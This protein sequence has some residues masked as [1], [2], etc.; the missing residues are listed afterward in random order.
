MAVLF[1]G[2]D[3]SPGG[4]KYNE[5]RCGTLQVTASSGRQLSVAVVCD[6]VGGEERGERA[7]QL[8]V[9]TFLHY[10]RQHPDEVFPQLLINGVQAA[11]YAV[12][13][14]A[15]LLG[16]A[17]RMACTLVAAVVENGSKAYIANVGDSRAYLCRAGQLR[18]LT[19]DHTFA[20]V[21]VWLGKL[22]TEAAAT[23]P[24]ANRVMRV[25]GTREDLQVDMGF[26]M[27]TTEYG[28]A[29]QIGRNGLALKRG[30][31]ILLCSDGLIKPTPRSRQKL[32]TEAEIARTL[33][34]LEGDK[35]AQALLGVAL[36][37]IPVGEQVD[38][39][40]VAVVQTPDPSR[41]RR[42]AL[43]SRR[44]QVLIALAVGLPLLFLLV[45]V[46][47]LFAGFFVFSSASAAGTATQL[48]Q[49]TLQ[50]ADRTRIAAGFTATPTL[51][52]T[53]LPTS[54]PTAV[55][56]EVAKVF[57]P[58]NLLQ[59]II[60]TDRVLVS[61][62]VTEPRYVA[63]TY[64]R[65]NAP[66]TTTDGNLYLRAG[67]QLQ[68]TVVTEKLFQLMLLPGSEVV[69]QT[70]PYARG[71]EVHLARSV[72]SVRVI[73]CLTLQ[74]LEAT[75][76]DL[77]CLNGECGISPDL[78]QP[79]VPFTSG[80]RKTLTL[81][82]TV[83][84]STDTP[85]P[86]AAEALWPLLSFTSVGLADA[87]LCRVPNVPATATAEANI[88]ATA[89]ATRAT[90]PTRTTTPSATPTSTNSTSNGAGSIISNPTLTSTPTLATLTSTPQ[91]SPAT[92][93]VAASKTPTPIPTPTDTDTPEP[94]ATE[95]PTA[96]D[97]PSPEPRETPSETPIS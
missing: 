87:P 90:Q 31:S 12:L 66:A 78:G 16:E 41:G 63:V 58:V 47:S 4:R 85:A 88:T 65:Y 83:T 40:T 60:D 48:A 81:G 72:A 59:T 32:I 51:T 52:P 38:N 49:A 11:N 10:F 73:G 33:G 54:V 30:D 69:I 27:E 91:P 74:F 68:F 86:N 22:S 67:S 64:A 46:S 36:G 70:G 89:R 17:E 80:T 53:P 1:L 43:S 19:R 61:A 57:S 75:Q 45:L 3:T 84:V 14:E 77:I 8:A 79:F 2:T 92:A 76:V 62:P 6:G 13:H 50:A 15:R 21:M 95:D 96:T 97:T 82:P 5:D 26:Y 55:P 39:I 56:G 94:T 23:N 34:T 18:P 29:N 37:R 9:D 20:N 25:I 24:E 44:N 71:A 7:A 42:L 35:A 28:L 93:T